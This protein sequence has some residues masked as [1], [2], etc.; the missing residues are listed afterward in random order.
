M[1]HVFKVTDGY[2]F[3][4]LSAIGMRLVN[5]FQRHYPDL[6]KP[7]EEP[8]FRFIHLGSPKQN[9]E[10]EKL[11]EMVRTRDREADLRPKPKPMSKG[12]LDRGRK[13]S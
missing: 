1:A 2:E 12:Q 3:V 10:L 8:N 9:A 11:V 7:A 6:C 5:E 13:L 4:R